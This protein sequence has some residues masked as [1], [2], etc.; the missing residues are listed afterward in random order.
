ML[1]LMTLS[2]VVIIMLN[3]LMLQINSPMLMLPLLIITFMMLAMVT[4]IYNSF[5]NWLSYTIFLIFVGGL[6][7]LFAYIVSLTPNTKLHNKNKHSFMLVTLVLMVL[8]LLSLLD[9][10]AMNLHS[11]NEQT[12]YTTQMNS[13]MLY[14]FSLASSHYT[15]IMMVFLFFIMIAVTI[16]LKSSYGALRIN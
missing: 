4:W 12:S 8:M 13:N 3:L 9:I 10:P 5:W 1:T 15:A 2:N 7:I 11:L 14:I 6:L 16:L